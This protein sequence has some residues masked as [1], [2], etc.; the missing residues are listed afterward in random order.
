MRETERERRRGGGNEEKRKH[1]R[2][3]C[4]I[5]IK[6]KETSPITREIERRGK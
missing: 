3:P 4:G 1:L 5:I 6:A 2:V